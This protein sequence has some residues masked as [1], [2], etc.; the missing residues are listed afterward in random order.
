MGHKELDI[1]H[2]TREP[3][4]MNKKKTHPE[5]KRKPDHKTQFMRGFAQQSVICN[6]KGA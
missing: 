1:S 2:L 5:E 3:A 4:T 6:V